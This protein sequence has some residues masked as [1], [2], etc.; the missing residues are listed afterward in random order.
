[1]NSH[2]ARCIQLLFANR[3]LEVFCLLMLNENFFI[4]KFAF[5]I[6]AENVNFA[7][8]YAVI[9]VIQRRL[10][11]SSKAFAPSSCVCSFSPSGS[12]QEEEE[13]KEEEK[14]LG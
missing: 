10:H 4:F 9:P 5:A 13:E 6:P 1:M 7:R 8:L 14:E 3:T 11:T 12:S 2:T